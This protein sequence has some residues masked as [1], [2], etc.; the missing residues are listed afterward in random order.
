MDLFL[1]V[2]EMA[3]DSIQRQRRLLAVHFSRVF[4]FDDLGEVA[5]SV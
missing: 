3:E 5:R 2:D 1:C 4:R